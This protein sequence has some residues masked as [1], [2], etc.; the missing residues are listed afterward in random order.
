M[1]Q[2]I[3]IVKKMNEAKTYK[4]HREL[5][6]YRR[7]F[8]EALRLCGHN[9][10]QMFIEADWEIAKPSMCAGVDMDHERRLMNDEL[11]RAQSRSESAVSS[12]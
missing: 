3:E 12:Q 8:C 10:G 6:N 7:G 1:K 2:Y 5:D 9:V 4:E 11:R